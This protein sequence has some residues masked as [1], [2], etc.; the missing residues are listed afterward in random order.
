M[1]DGEG[2]PQGTESHGTLQ[3][4]SIGTAENRGTL[5]PKVEAV[6]IVRTAE[7]R[8]ERRTVAHVLSLG[9]EEVL[10]RR[11]IERDDAVAG[12]ASVPPSSVE[13]G[14]GRVERESSG[15]QRALERGAQNA[16]RRR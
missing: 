2:I 4:N 15:A 14:K 13:R 11:L 10:L 1:L 5:E 3:E 16:E 8:R 12:S 6:A 7:I 9:E